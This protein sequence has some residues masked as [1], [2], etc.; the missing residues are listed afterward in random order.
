[1][2]AEVQAGLDR[3]DALNQAPAPYEPGRILSPLTEGQEFVSEWDPD[4]AYDEALQKSAMVDRCTYGLAEKAASVPLRVWERTAENP[5]GSPVPDHELDDVLNNPA[6]DPVLGSREELVTRTIVHHK[7]VGTA[8]TGIRRGV[9]VLSRRRGATRVVGLV[10]EDPRQVYPVPSSALKVAKWNYRDGD[11]R[12]LAWN[13]EDLA[14][15]KRHDPRNA[16]WGRSVLQ[17]LAVTVDS[18]VQNARTHLLRVAR[19]GR[20]GMILQDETIASP[21][22]GRDREKMLNAR[23]R[24]HRGGIMLLGGFEKLVAAGMSSDDLGILESMAFDRDMIAI[25]FGFLPAGFSNDAATYANSGIF[26]LHEW[27]LV[28][29]TLASWTSV[30]TSFLF[31][32]EERRRFYIA[33]DFSE[34]QALADAS[35][36]KIKILTDA[37]FRGVS[38]NDLIRSLGL[39]IPAQEG[40]DAVL[41]PAKM[42]RLSDALRTEG[43]P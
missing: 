8:L 18:S 32:R 42:Q 24:T 25:A 28:Q 21:D 41:V 39:P 9:D 37:A 19:D 2:I 35:M 4:R 40:G 26:V 12:Q 6:D 30:L 38:T 17:A 14:A 36:D 5:K 31:T 33:A 13:R 15:W 10:A 3:L 29:Q 23:Q 11:G 27:G 7:I 22:Q 34:V 43:T 16:V 1:M 20:P